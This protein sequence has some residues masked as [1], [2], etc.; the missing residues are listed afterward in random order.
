MTPDGV[1]SSILASGRWA[2]IHSKTLMRTERTGLLCVALLFSV[3]ATPLRAQKVDFVKQ[4]APILATRCVECHG[5]DEPEADLRLDV[6]AG[7]FHDTKEDWVVIPGKSG[8]SVLYERV[9]LPADDDE[10]MPADGK[11]L[12]KDQIG[13]LKAWIDQGAVW[14]AEADAAM[15]ALL[16]G[17]NKPKEEALPLPK[18]SAAEKAAEDKVL[19]AIEKAGGL[20]MRVAAN[21]PAT[22]VNFSLL[23]SKAKD[24]MVAETK[25]LARTLIRANLARTPLG[26]AAV[27]HLAACKQLR[28]LNLSNTAVTDAGLAGLAALGELRYLNLYGTK[29][30]D[31]GLAKL[32]GMANLEKLYLWQTKVSKKG[33]AALQKALPKVKVDRGEY[34]AILAKVKPVAA[35]KKMAPINKT[36]PL[37]GKPAS[38]NHVSVFEGQVIGFCCAKCKASFD[39]NPKKVLGKIKE[40]KVASGPVA[41]AKCPVS[42]KGLAKGQTSNFRG[43]VIGF[44]CGKCKAAFDKNPNKFM[45]KLKGVFAAKKGKAAKKRKAKK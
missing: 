7:L 12:S 16:A 4:V 2:R 40:F 14:P 34:A 8:E 35:K 43:K 31:A 9:I 45:P 27:A 23:G 17:G 28:W 6:K 11:P 21:S 37:A 26:D 25:G 36:C 1:A 39:K 18:L 5:A 3:L 41:N 10:L 42:G 13:V 30:T 38:P 32:H 19:A 29:I 44:C 22:E 15:A 33:V 20:A 24:G